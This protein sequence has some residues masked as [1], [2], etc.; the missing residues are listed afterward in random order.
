M[1]KI[2]AALLLSSALA[3]FAAPTY[4]AS[5]PGDR[6]AIENVVETFRVSLIKKDKNS[7]MKLFYSENIPWIGITTDKSLAMIKAKKAKPE[8]PDPKKVYA[9]DNP[10]KFIEG[11]VKEKEAV[12]EKFENVRID[13]NGDV[14]QVWFDYSFNYDGY[15]ANWG[16]EAWHMVRTS[17]GWKISSVIWSMEFNPEPPPKLEKKKS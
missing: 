6:A 1:K 11:I 15:K 17:D 3:A 14:A 2:Y 4:A 5:E 12:E 13:S 16:K 8:L 9:S 7:F 10:R